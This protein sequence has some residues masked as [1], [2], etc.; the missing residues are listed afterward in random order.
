MPIRFPRTILIEEAR[1][2]EGAASLRLDCESI[3]VAP[4]GLTVDGVEVRQLL[5]LGWTP[6][7]LSFESNGQAY[8][9]DINGVAVIR[10]SRAVF[11]FA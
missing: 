2:A 9:F 4:G 1:L 11:P 8:H 5:A 7:C 3:T 10:P 6:R